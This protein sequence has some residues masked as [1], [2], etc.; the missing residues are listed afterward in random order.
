VGEVLGEA[1]QEPLEGGTPP[2]PLQKNQG[3]IQV[4]IQSE[5]TVGAGENP[6]FQR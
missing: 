6:I 5:P 1:P 3:S 2:R 4:P